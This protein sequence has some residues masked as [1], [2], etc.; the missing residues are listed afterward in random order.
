MKEGEPLY[1]TTEAAEML[2][3][4]PA[5]V[6][7]MVL[8]GTIQAEKKGRDLLITKSQIEKAKARKT[9]PGP[10]KAAKKSSKK[11]EAK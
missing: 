8:D 1:T 6:R 2:A 3:V 4:T 11:V 10:T 5:R 9:T 7:Q